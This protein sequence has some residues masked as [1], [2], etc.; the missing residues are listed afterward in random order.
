MGKAGELIRTVGLGQSPLLHVLPFFC[1]SFRGYF[2]SFLT[3]THYY[4]L[5]TAHQ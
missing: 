4:M 2:L 5:G 1:C 3:N